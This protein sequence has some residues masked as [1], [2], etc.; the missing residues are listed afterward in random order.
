M[1]NLYIL[2]ITVFFF[3]TEIK[4]TAQHPFPVNPKNINPE[5]EVGTLSGTFAVGQ[6]GAATYTIPIDL[7]EGRVGMTPELGLV[8][9]SQQGNNVMGQG[10]HISGFSSISRT[11]TTTYYNGEIDNVRLTDFG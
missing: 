10:W 8:Y 9:S 6:T 11:N 5:A 4:L 7:P 3:Q 2:L 1:K